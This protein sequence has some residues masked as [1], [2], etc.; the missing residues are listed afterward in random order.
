LKVSKKAS[1]S[2]VVL[3]FATQRKFGAWLARHHATASGIWIKLAKAASGITSIKYAEAVEEALC[4]GWID[5]QTKGVDEHWYVQRFTPRGKRSPW[6]KINCTKA[7]ALIAS[8]KMK[9]AGLAEVERAKKDGRWDRAYDSPAGATVPPDLAAALARNRR[10]S[11]FFQQLNSVN[12]YA[13]LHR[14]Q[15]ARRPETRARR[16]DTFVKMLARR[17]KLHP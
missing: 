5:S 2:E 1:A 6:S 17:E 4:W 7:A 11:A 15:T 12:R 10:A 9:L 13:I 3:P 8:G 16:I 14:L